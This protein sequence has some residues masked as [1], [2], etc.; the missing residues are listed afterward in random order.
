MIKKYEARQKALADFDPSQKLDFD[1]LMASV[2]VIGGQAKCVGCSEP[3]T[4]E[5][6]NK[7][8]GAVTSF[9]GACVGGIAQRY[10]CFVICLSS[11]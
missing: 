7:E 8:A 3:F 10:L 9:C 6:C 2:H 4:V 5:A 11:L 1:H